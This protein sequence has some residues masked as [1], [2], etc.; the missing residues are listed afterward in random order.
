MPLGFRVEYT[1]G[2]R[3]G[4]FFQDPEIGVTGGWTEAAEP[5]LA[6]QGRVPAEQVDKPITVPRTS[7]APAHPE[8]A[9]SRLPALWLE[10]LR[11]PVWAILIV[12]QKSPNPGLIPLATAMYRQREPHRSTR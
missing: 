3:A 6:P 4:R 7:A 9:Q 12:R 2:A 8:Q 11:G 10:H 1:V 5:V